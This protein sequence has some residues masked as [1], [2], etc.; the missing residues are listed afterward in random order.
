MWPRDFRQN[1]N[2]VN[3]NM[4]FTEIENNTWFTSS[5]NC[6]LILCQ[7]NTM[8]S[9]FYFCSNNCTS[10]NYLI[11][12]SYGSWMHNNLCNQSPSPLNFWIQILSIEGVL[13]TT[14]YDQVCQW[15]ATDFTRV[16]SINK[17]DHHDLTE[18]LLKVALNTINLNLANW[19]R[20]NC[21]F[22]G[23]LHWHVVNYQIRNTIIPAH[24][25]TSI[26]QSSVLKGHLFLVLSFHMNWAPF[27]RSPVL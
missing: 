23:I 22:F 15:F 20:H 7:K 10:D 18:I 24:A 11:N 17:T 4:L 2:D 19:R 12:W 9:D 6:E 8:D 26:K 5:W 21:T 1:E 14:F 16:S 25:V 3:S 13:D 27:K